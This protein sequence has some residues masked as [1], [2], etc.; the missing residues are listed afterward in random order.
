MV[1]KVESYSRTLK[2]EGAWELVSHGQTGFRCLALHTLTEYQSLRVNGSWVFFLRPFLPFERRL[3]LLSCQAT[4]NREL[5]LALIPANFIPIF[6][7]G[8]YQEE[9]E[10]ELTFRQP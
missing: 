8:R 6:D 7:L 5:R 1:I 10:E 3:F 9:A 4:S 2:E